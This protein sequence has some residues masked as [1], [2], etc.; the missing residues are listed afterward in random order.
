MGTHE[1]L[2]SDIGKFVDRA[3]WAGIPVQAEI[4][5]GMFHSWQIF[6]GQVPEGREAI[7]QA[8]AFI[9]SILSR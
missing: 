9:R 8:G 4:W 1:L 5:E 7:D 2:L 6:A 3:R